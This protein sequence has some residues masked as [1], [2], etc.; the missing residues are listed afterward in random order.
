MAMR[1]TIKEKSYQYT[2]TLKSGFRITSTIKPQKKT[3]SS[4]GKKLAGGC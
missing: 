4:T 1:P 3:A 2:A